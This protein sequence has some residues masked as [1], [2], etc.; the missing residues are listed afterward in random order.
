MT[1]ASPPAPGPAGVIFDLDGVLIDSEGLQYEAYSRVLAPYGVRVT[2]EE[3]GREFIGNGRGAEWA[4][5]TFALP[6]SADELKRQKVPVYAELLH[7]KVQLMPGAVECLERLAPV[8][9]LA[10][11]TNS[12]ASELGFVLDRFAIARFFTVVV[13]REKYERPK[14]EPDAF[15]AAA[16]GLGMPP[17]RCVVVEDAFKG[18]KAAHGAGCPCLAVPHD[19]TRNNDFS[20]AT[21]VLRS[22][23][24]VTVDLI[25]ELA[26]GG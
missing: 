24:E 13:A 2:Y 11:A 23:D 20:L 25:A 4:V 18:V 5:R 16:A 7:E 3:Y 17:R 21:R 22:I 1:P 10:V 12:L 14:P 6:V 9:P 26:V 15:L 19:F 8:Y